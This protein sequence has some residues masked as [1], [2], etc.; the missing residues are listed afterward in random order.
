M[1]P[2]S[3]PPLVSDYTLCHV[4]LVIIVNMI[5][6]EL[7]HGLTFTEVYN[8]FDDV[9]VLSEGHIIYH[10]VREEVRLTPLCWFTPLSWFIP[11]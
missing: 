7:V 5:A 11:L 3:N 4:K 2:F 1:C 10:G 9:M 8:L 6:A